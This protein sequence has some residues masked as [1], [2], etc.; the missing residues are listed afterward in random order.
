VVVLPR[1]DDIADLMNSFDVGVVTS[2]D[3]E[4]ISRVLLEYMFLQKPV[5]GTKI[6]AIGEIIQPGINGDLISPGDATTLSD[7]IV[8]LLEKDRLR[9]KYGENSLRL[10]QR[11][12]SEERFYEKTDQVFEKILAIS[13][14]L[15][16]SDH[17]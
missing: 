14:G 3:S 2:T 9:A 5:I 7:K 13:E 11:N 15:K 16:L 10:Y 17:L 4:T 1:I 8:H 6:N 12:Y